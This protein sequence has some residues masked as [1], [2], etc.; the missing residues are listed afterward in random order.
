MV[1]KNR[2]YVYLDY[3]QTRLVFSTAEFV[4]DMNRL[5]GLSYCGNIN[6]DCYQFVV[7]NVKQY[8]IAKIKYGF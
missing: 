3:D 6:R 2:Q 8:M 7:A 5:F 1:P 4:Y